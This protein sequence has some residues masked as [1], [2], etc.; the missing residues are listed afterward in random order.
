MIVKRQNSEII[1]RF[2]AGTEI[3]RIQSILDYLRY[4]EL[5]TRSDATEK[6]SGTLLKEIKKGRWNKIK[7]EVGFSA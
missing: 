5:T 3:S 6:E 1:I 4:E 2:E 7:K